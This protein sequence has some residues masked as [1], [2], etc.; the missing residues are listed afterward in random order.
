[1]RK[2]FTIFLVF[3]EFFG[4]LD[5]AAKESG[6]KC[7]GVCIFIARLGYFLISPLMFLAEL[8]F[9]PFR[10]V[11]WLLSSDEPDRPV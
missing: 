5:E 11:Y 3:K 1:M 9:L 6:G 7:G 10:R 4:A 8:T 2:K